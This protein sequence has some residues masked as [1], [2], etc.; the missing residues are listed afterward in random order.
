V[1]NLLESVNRY[2]RYHKNISGLVFFGSPSIHE[3]IL[4]VGVH[5]PVDSN[6]YIPFIFTGKNIVL[7]MVSVVRCLKFCSQVAKRTY[8]DVENLA[9][10]QESSRWLALSKP[11]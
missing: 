4:S 2:Q 10:L 11:R 8:W 9:R 6:I 1:K 5:S 3:Q 7:K